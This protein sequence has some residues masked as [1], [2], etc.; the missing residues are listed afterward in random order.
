MAKRAARKTR[1]AVIA[2]AAAGVF[3]LGIAGAAM[4]TTDAPEHGSTQGVHTA[5]QKHQAQD[6]PAAVAKVSDFYNGYV[7]ARG[8]NDQQKA[9]S[10]RQDNLTAK[11]QQD[12]SAWEKQHGA[13]GVLQ[14]QNVPTKVDVTYDGSGMGHSWSW[15]TLTWDGGKTS[16]L[17]VQSDLDSQKV[18]DIKQQ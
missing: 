8:Q 1:I 18:S 7:A 17:H 3:S 15:V 16:K 13:D 4:A 5:A 10:L 6:D 12:L 14:S 11:F 9:D 2:G